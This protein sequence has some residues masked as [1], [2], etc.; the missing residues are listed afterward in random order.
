MSTLASKSVKFFERFNRHS[1]VIIGIE[2]VAAMERLEELI[3]VPGVDGVFLGPHDIS[4]SMELPEEWD[5]PA[6][7]DAMEN[8]IVRCRAANVGVGAHLSPTSFPIENMQ[9]FIDA[10]MNWV[11]DGA[12]VAHAIVSL[13][14]RREAFGNSGALPDRADAS[15]DPQSCVI[16]D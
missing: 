4:I 2:S 6:F 10:G 8:I 12:D 13:R 5:N 3:S 16:A 1:Y 14:Q 7:L 15:A 9:R 11:L